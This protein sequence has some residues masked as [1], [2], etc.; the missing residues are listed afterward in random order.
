MRQQLTDKGYW[1][2][3]SFH[4]RVV[5]RARVERY[6]NNSWVAVDCGWIGYRVHPRWAGCPRCGAVDVFSG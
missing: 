3:G 6:S 5:C 4:Y 2:G 1:R